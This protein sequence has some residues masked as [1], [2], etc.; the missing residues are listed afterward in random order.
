MSQNYAAEFTRLGYAVAD[1]VLPLPSVLALRD[2]VAA[3]RQGSE[4]RRR[5]DVY[6]VRN[7]LEIS[8]GVRDLASTPEIRKFVTPLLGVEAFAA[9]AIF[10][11]KVEGANWGLGWHQ[12]SVI[13]VKERHETPGF[14]AWSQKSGVW[15]VQ[16]PASDLAKMVAVRVHLDECPEDNGPLLVIPGSH[17]HGWLDD[18]I[19]EW[20]K[21][22]PIIPCTVGCGGVVVMCPL[23][24]HASPPANK[25]RHRR[26][27]H[28]EFAA[29]E[30][31][32]D[33]DWNN[34]I[35]A[36]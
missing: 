14:D 9:R 16:P 19:D 21:R 2:V 1:D 35:G 24:L 28:F 5:R 7:L 11:D 29:H 27:I 10:F 6:G 12:D 33:L 4:V 30:L 25:P 13:S 17:R 31:S 3:I 26:V 23:T 20:K 18:E 15:Q 32:G 22:G 36:P 8:A 34:R